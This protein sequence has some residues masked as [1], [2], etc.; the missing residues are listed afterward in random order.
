MSYENPQIPEGIN[1][2]R[3]NPLKEFVILTIGVLGSAA[4]ITVLLVQLIGWW[5]PLIPF[6]W[7][8]D[9]SVSLDDTPQDASAKQQDIEVY[10]NKLTSALS[11]AMNLPESMHITAHFV[12]DDTVNGFATLGGHIYI[13]RGLLALLDSENALALLLAHEIAHIKNRDPLVAFARH[14]GVASVLGLITGTSNMGDIGS[15]IG[16]VS[17]LTSLGFNRSMESTAD[18]DGLHAVYQHY[19]HTNGAAQLFVVLQQQSKLAIPEF[20]STHPLSENRVEELQ[21]LAEHN[22]W[23][24]T[25][26]TTPLPASIRAYLK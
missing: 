22:Q 14:V 17:T 11:T 8:Q 19:G 16:V 25:G 3:E 4:I 15:G 1:N 13:H 12:D 21:S 6:S 20:I 26:S 9:W 2:T 10:L 18:H 24:Q 7:E 23:K 5:A